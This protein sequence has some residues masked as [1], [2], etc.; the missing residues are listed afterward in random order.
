MSKELLKQYEESYARIQ[1]TS[2]GIGALK[3]INSIQ[4]KFRRTNGD[5]HIT[6]NEWSY[7]IAQYAELPK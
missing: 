1:R 6:Y 7:F 2:E 4:T 3:V 5:I